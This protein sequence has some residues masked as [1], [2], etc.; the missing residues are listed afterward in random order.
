LETPDILSPKTAALLP[1][2]AEAYTK[3]TGVVTIGTRIAFGSA[4]AAWYTVKELG[5]NSVTGQ[6]EPTPITSHVPTFI[7]ASANLKITG[8]QAAD[9]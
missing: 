7:P 3:N 9:T 5:T 2:S 8:S 4:T 6:K 1:L